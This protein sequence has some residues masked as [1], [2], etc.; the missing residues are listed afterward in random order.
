M[1]ALVKYEPYVNNTIKTFLA[2]LETRFCERPGKE[3]AI[4]FPEWLQYYA[5]DV[6]GELTY[7]KRHG[8]LD[9]GEDV[10]NIIHDSH[11][12]LV[13]CFIASSVSS[14]QTLPHN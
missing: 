10:G 7:G 9:T 2:V 3:G 13:Y 12:F 14:H 4:D 8:F 6:V 11:Q 5:F 1:T